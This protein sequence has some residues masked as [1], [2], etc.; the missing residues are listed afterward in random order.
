M[1][2]DLWFSDPKDISDYKLINATWDSMNTQDVGL[3]TNMFFSSLIKG[4]QS[5]AISSDTVDAT[6]EQMKIHWKQWANISNSFADDVERG[7][8]IS[9]LTTIS[10]NGFESGHPSFNFYYQPFAAGIKS[11]YTKPADC[12]DDDLS[13]RC[14]SSKEAIK[15]TIKN[16]YE[17]IDLLH[18][19]SQKYRLQKNVNLT[20][21]LID[22]NGKLSSREDVESYLYDLFNRAQ[23]DG[24]LLSM[25]GPILRIIRQH[26]T[27]R[28]IDVGL[29]ERKGE[30]IVKI[31]VSLEE[32]KDK[33]KASTFL[34]GSPETYLKLADG[35]ISKSSEL[36]SEHLRLR[37]NID[38]LE[39]ILD[40]AE[41]G[42]D[43]YVLSSLGTSIFN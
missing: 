16:T 26:W 9:A 42:S 14:T 29:A 6:F 30:K 10:G 41:N 40:V 1:V 36:E 24:R 18:P 39:Y 19:S 22:K 32:L 27:Q 3:L 21:D 5:I 20:R 7:M 8:L 23:D 15:E 11:F 17:M 25:V 43:D 34:Y 28:M 31:P 38:A 13:Q 33:L 4:L 35:R 12:K 37:S 2:I